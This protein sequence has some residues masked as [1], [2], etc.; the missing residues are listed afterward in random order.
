MEK[1][2]HNETRV[3]ERTP[4]TREPLH[5]EESLLKDIEV[6]K[7]KKDYR[8]ILKELG[9]DRFRATLEALYEQE[10]ALSRVGRRI[11]AKYYTV[12]RWMKRM[13]IP[14]ELNPV[15]AQKTKILGWKKIPEVKYHLPKLPIEELP[16]KEKMWIAGLTEG[17]A[18]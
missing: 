8:L 18:E 10:G 17:E 1:V 16:E 6:I 3:K 13:A 2:V 9:Y 4:L 12:S 11:G 5:E 14:F 15:R 7:R